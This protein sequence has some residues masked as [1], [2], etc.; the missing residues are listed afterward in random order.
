MSF[1]HLA[2]R[3][4]SSRLASS[5]PPNGIQEN[6]AEIYEVL[7]SSEQIGRKQEALSGVLLLQTSEMSSFA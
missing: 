2:L 6:Q 1:S 7:L 5:V 3:M 4:E